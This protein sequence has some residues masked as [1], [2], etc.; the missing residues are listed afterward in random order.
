MAK[1][2]SLKKG[3]E[4]LHRVDLVVTDDRELLRRQ[5]AREALLT[6]IGRAEV[7]LADARAILEKEKN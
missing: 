7:A 4:A 2:K 3:K 5:G 1:K 6:T